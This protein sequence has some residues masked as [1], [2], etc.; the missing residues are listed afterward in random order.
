L[1]NLSPSNS[2]KDTSS[3]F[4]KDIEGIMDQF[5]FDPKESSPIQFSPSSPLKNLS[6]G[7]L[8]AKKEQKLETGKLPMKKEQPEVGKLPP[9]LQKSN[10]EGMHR[11][12]PVRPQAVD[13]IN[14]QPGQPIPQFRPFMQQVR[15]GYRPYR[16][17]YSH[18]PQYS[19]SE[20]GYNQQISD[21]GFNGQQMRPGFTPQ[22]RPR[23][24][25]NMQPNM[26]PN[27]SPNMQPQG[28]WSPNQMGPG[29]RPFNVVVRPRDTNP[30]D[31]NPTP[32]GFRPQ[33]QQGRP[34]NSQRY[35]DGPRYGPPQNIQTQQMRPG[36]PIVQNQQLRNGSP[37][38]QNQQPRPGAPIVQNQQMRHG[39][40]I[41]QQ[42]PMA[43]LMNNQRPPD[44]PSS[45]EKRKFQMESDN[46]KGQLANQY[47]QNQMLGPPQN[48][49]LA[50]PNTTGLGRRNSINFDP[51][52][53]ERIKQGLN[54]T[55]SMGSQSNTDYDHD[56]RNMNMQPDLQVRPTFIATLRR[57][58]TATEQIQRLSPAQEVQ[59]RR[60]DAQKTTDPKVHFEFA[61]ACL[62]AGDEYVEEGFTLLKKVANSG[63]PEA[64]FF[65]G[66]AFADDGKDEM[67]YGQY[68]MAAKRGY[69]PACHAIGICAENGR[70]CKKN[71]RLAL[72]MYN[73][74]AT[75]GD[76]HSMYRLG[77]AELHG[78]MGLKHDVQKAAK[79]FKR[80]CA[81]ILN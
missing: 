49:M 51:E 67:A 77:L 2:A 18:R 45:P 15:P 39:S 1:K 13:M 31:L 75:S 19:K 71:T 66:D 16:P 32:A 64:H 81:G 52:L 21:V 25:E 53:A 76:L 74:A 5:G 73:K 20:V 54:Q 40:P 23:P 46:F 7:E 11:P 42:R 65:L 33:Y 57:N 43:P 79:W 80:A 48:Q 41:V 35:Q 9:P 3:S 12:L 36:S 59:M 68:L 60:E 44:G 62:A 10:T 22:M 56:D 37:I 24:V 47:A 8:P 78:S 38:V 4:T 58:K 55:D 27:M 69:A 61:K 17:Q 70:G 63:Y 30:P 14:G 6:L 28:M 34:D 50:V 72:E 26:S 29:G